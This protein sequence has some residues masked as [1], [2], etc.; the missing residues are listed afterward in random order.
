[1]YVYRY[2]S[3]AHFDILIIYFHNYSI[4]LLDEKNSM[5]VMKNQSHRNFS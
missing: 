4:F 2:S 3:K 5:K 1:M